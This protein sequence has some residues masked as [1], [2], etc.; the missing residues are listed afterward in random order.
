ML[1]FLTKEYIKN[2]VPWLPWIVNNPNIL[3]IKLH[4]TNFKCNNFK[5]IETMGLKI[6]ASRPL[7]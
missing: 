1:N 3:V 5:M 6:I 2:L 4:V 7:E